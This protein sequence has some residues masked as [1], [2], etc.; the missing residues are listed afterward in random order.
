VPRVAQIGEC[1]WQRGVEVAFPSVSGSQP[2]NYNRNGKRRGVPP[3]LSFAPPLASFEGNKG[4]PGTCAVSASDVALRT[5]SPQG[6][7]GGPRWPLGPP[8]PSLRGAESR[9]LGT[10][11]PDH[12]ICPGR[13]I[14][15]ECLGVSARRFGGFISSTG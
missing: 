10:S 15:S 5:L 4:G 6:A 13:G 8:L 12:R 11:S 1:F 9:K 2:K 7:S 3:H 14:A